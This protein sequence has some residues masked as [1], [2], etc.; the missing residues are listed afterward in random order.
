MSANFFS[1]DDTHW[2]AV[3]RIFTC[4][5]FTLNFGILYQA[6]KKEINLIDFSN[7]DYA[8]DVDSRRSISGFAFFLCS[9]VLTW[10][11]ERQKLV[12]LSTIEAEN[13]AVSAVA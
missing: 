7:S 11:Y 12:T 2:K 6:N 4:E 8:A 9:G 5:S 1:R 13:V 3:K 10:S